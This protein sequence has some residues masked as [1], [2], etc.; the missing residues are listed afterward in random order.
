MGIKGLR[1]VRGHENEVDL[2]G[3]RSM[4]NLSIAGIGRLEIM[5]WKFRRYIMFKEWDS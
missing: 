4:Q 2:I 5:S 1:R 3:F